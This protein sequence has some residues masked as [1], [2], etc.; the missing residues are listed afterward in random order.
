MTIT[1]TRPPAPWQP[2]EDDPIL[3]A[4][5]T[6]GYASTPHAEFV[7]LRTYLESVVAD[8]RGPVHTAV[9]F[10]AAY[11]GYTP[12]DG[13]GR[14]PV[15][16]DAFPVLSL[17]HEVPAVPVGALVRVGVG[18]SDKLLYAEIVYKE[19]CRLAGDDTEEIPSWI[20]GAPADMIGPGIRGEAGAVRGELLVPDFAAF[21]P[22]LLMDEA[23]LGALRRRQK[24]LDQNGHLQVNARY[25]SASGARRSGKDAF[26][27]YMLAHQRDTLS[28]PH[29]PASLAGLAGSRDP[30]R[31]RA[32]FNG[33]LDVVEY[34]LASSAELR[35][36]QSYALTRARVGSGLADSGPLGQSDLVTLTNS[37]YRGA[38]PAE[39]RRYG[40]GG[41][42]TT[43]TGISSWLLSVRDS[44]DRLR[45]V[46]YAVSVCRANL[47]L[48]D[49]VR[50]SD[51]GCFT[52]GDVRIT[53][54]DSFV[55]GGIWRA[56]HPGSE[57]PDGDPFLAAGRGWRDAVQPPAAEGTYDVGHPVRPLQEI[58]VGADAQPVAVETEAAEP[59]DDPL[60][61]DAHL[62][63]PREGRIT[64]SEVAWQV[65]LRLGHI[66]EGR[67]PLRLIVRDLLEYL[68]AGDRA[69]LELVHPG[70]EI[71]ETEAVQD[72]ELALTGET[73]DIRGIDWPIDFFPGLYLNVQ[74]PKG[75][76]VFYLS[77]VALETPV[78]VDGQLIAHRYDPQILTRENAPGSGRHS[79]S[80]K[81]LDSRGLVLRA[82]RR[83]GL[84]TYD[85]HALMDRAALPRTVYGATPSPDQV[86]DLDRAVDE[87]ISEQR[88][89]SVAGS[90]DR[91]GEPSF[92][93]R[94]GDES[95]LLVGHDPAPRPA[96]GFGTA[97]DRGSTG[98]YHATSYRVRG[99]LR[100]LPAGSLPSSE[101]QDAYRAHCRWI[102][103]ADGWELP[104]GFTF[105]TEHDRTR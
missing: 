76:I 53:L 78:E 47:A 83:C 30:D 46:E 90:R 61:D 44:G 49:Y 87:L 55:L 59:V 19:G 95:I 29:V 93:A 97:S 18:S 77:T 92:P 12:G 11:L 101:Q 62:G 15:D 82:V 66:V 79:D 72:V 39:R 24:W 64:D 26:V 63:G 65:P 36:W 6:G 91:H 22:A 43:Y 23:K 48:S 50:E 9:A 8:R 4:A 68:G 70:G 45:D 105:V 89:Y 5:M 20:S 33:L 52:D 35:V 88:L 1:S 21:G 2:Y 42:R 27:D 71:D 28:D 25:A 41:S 73:G 67:L 54:D 10:N 17:G 60:R 40:G 57:E 96:V 99:F 51:G 80:A 86:R 3:T 37:V 74:W 16:L 31:L 85:G 7:R 100:R 102:G 38:V 13:Y 84:L 103:K 81:G 75:G 14:G 58:S 98:S 32:A 56:H 69:R 34:A 94:D 104:R